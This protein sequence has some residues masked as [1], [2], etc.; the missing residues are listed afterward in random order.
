MLDRTNFTG[1]VK[2]FVRGLWQYLREVSGEGDYA[3]YRT[4]ALAEG[5]KLMTPREFYQV[6]QQH[7]Y[8]RPNRCC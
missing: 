4:R 2:T 1:P 8:C 3:R 7:K 6:Q 5:E